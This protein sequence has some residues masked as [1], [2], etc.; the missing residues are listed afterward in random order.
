MNL[1]L[2]ARSG[3]VSGRSILISGTARSGTTVTGKIL[4]SFKNVEYC[5][6]PPTLFSLFPLIDRLAEEDWRLLYQTYLYEDYFVNALAGRSINT[7]RND[8]SSI[9][10][11]KGL[12]EI[13]ER[14]SAT[15]RRRDLDQVNGTI[16]YKMCDILAYIPKFLTY[17]PETRIV[18][19]YREPLANL[20]SLLEKRWFNTAMQD[21]NPYPFVFY[22]NNKIPYWVLSSDYD[23]WVSMNEIDRCAYYYIV[24]NKAIERIDSAIVVNYDRFIAAPF[25]VVSEL[26]DRLG[27]GFGEKTSEIIDSVRLKR[28]DVNLTLVD[29]I[30]QPLRAVIEEYIHKSHLDTD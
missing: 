6:E 11:I 24:M 14:L 26:S 17:Y 30:S 13:N 5:Y 10:G 8:D 7:N 20:S 9:Y 16:A 2:S 3:E 25:E 19:V 15:R 21:Y 28:R 4:G 23:Q 18:L 12:D 29:Q 1:T 27:L 22:R